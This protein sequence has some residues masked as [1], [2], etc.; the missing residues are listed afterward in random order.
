MNCDCTNSHCPKSHRHPNLRDPLVVFASIDCFSIFVRNREYPHL[1]DARIAHELD[2]INYFC[3]IY[4]HR[5]SLKINSF[6]YLISRRHRRSRFIL[7]DFCSLRQSVHQVRLLDARVEDIRG[8]I[9]ME[10]YKQNLKD[11]HTFHLMQ[12]R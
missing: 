4:L 9:G 8:I 1:Y 3:G 5:L 10:K 12:W 11:R 7:F 6:N 2:G